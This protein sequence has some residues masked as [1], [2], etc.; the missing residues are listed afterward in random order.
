MERGH[1]VGEQQRR[2]RH[3][4]LAREAVLRSERRAEDLRDIAVGVDQEV[5]AREANG[6]LA[7]PCDGSSAAM[8]RLPLAGRAVGF[9]LLREWHCWNREQARVLSSRAQQH[10]GRLG[11]QGEEL[12]MRAG[13][14]FRE[15][16][17]RGSQPSKFGA[18]A[19]QC[20][21]RRAQERRC[22][23]RQRGN[24]RQ[25]GRGLAYPALDDRAFHTFTFEQCT[26]QYRRQPRRRRHRLRRLLARR[27]A[28]RRRMCAEAPRTPGLDARYGRE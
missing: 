19:F 10:A 18:D 2:T 8:L 22:G 11:L 1:A 15:C 9:P 27:Q 13:L 4:D 6:A 14:R 23:A 5:F 24:G 3:A 26:S 20:G 12:R 17:L 7:L 28:H 16:L 25:A 21:M